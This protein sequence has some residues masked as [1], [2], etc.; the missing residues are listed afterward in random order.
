DSVFDFDTT[1]LSVNTFGLGL[2]GIEVYDLLR[3]EYDIQIEFGDLGNF[4]AYISVGDK[5]KNI[6]R[7]ISA[8]S[9]IRRI[10]KKDNENMLETEYI[11]PTVVISPQE[12]FYAEKTSLP[13][14]ECGGRVCTEFVMCYPPGIPILAPGERITREIIA[15]IQYAKEKG[16][17]ITGPES[18]DISRLN[19]W[20][21]E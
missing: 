9:E 20:K 7:L 15:Y 19:V 13:L 11:S 1:K 2:A 8:L 18:M 12:A 6:E 5:N 10:Y 21:G 4:L 17:V 16:C 3:D 14:A